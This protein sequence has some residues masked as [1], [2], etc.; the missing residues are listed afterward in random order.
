M[1]LQVIKMR[2]IIRQKKGV[3]I[4][5]A[6]VLLIIIAIT[7][8]IFVYGWLKKYIP[9]QSEECDD[10]VALNIE[11]YCFNHTIP[12][13][14][15]IDIRIRNN[16]LFNVNGFFIRIST[17]EGIA[18]IP[19]EDAGVRN[20]KVYVPLKTGE[21]YAHGFPADFPLITTLEIEP[22][23]I[24]DDQTILCDSSIVNIPID[25]FR[26]CDAY[27]GSGGCDNDGI[28]EADEDII[29]C[30][31]DCGF[32]DPDGD[33]GT[34]GWE[35]P[36]QEPIPNAH[37]DEIDDGVRSGVGDGNLI[38]SDVDNQ[39]DIFS[40]EDTNLGTA[41]VNQIIVHFYAKAGEN[42]GE[43]VGIDIYDGTWINYQVINVPYTPPVETLDWYS[44]SFTGSFIETQINN[45]LVKVNSEGPHTGSEAENDFIIDALYVELVE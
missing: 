25:M 37:F 1:L 28:C 30:P 6:Y 36:L 16:G 21:D 34:P 32:L 10:G 39:I 22:F 27:G 12:G 14:P 29:N 4:M 13:E 19:L 11:S 33:I 24:K 7:L 18:A 17:D 45:L 43:K 26:V 38:M 42:S 5:V 20:G 35:D 2:K 15:K 8:A 23:I 41:S 40:I 44:A 3:S 9:K 31:A